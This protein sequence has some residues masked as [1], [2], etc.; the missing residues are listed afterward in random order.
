MRPLQDGHSNDGL[1]HGTQATNKD[2]R[3]WTSSP[4]TGSPTTGSP[5]PPAGSPE[6]RLAIGRFSFAGLAQ[7]SV[8]S[9]VTTNDDVAAAD[10]SPSCWL[11]VWPVSAPSVFDPRAASLQSPDAQQPLLPPI[12]P[13]QFAYRSQTDPAPPFPSPSGY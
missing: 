6:M 2:C 7:A 3:R 5:P 10:S 4:P 12:P 11:L 1:P 13:M 8:H 9:P